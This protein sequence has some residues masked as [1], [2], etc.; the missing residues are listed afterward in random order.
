MGMEMRQEL[1]LSQQLVMTPQLQQAIKL[2]QLSRMELVDLVREEML[3][4][5]V[6]EE[7]S[8]MSPDAQSRELVGDAE[9]VTR[10]VE[11]AGHTELP[12]A[13]SNKD[14]ASEVKA[15]DS[16]VGEIDWES[17]L[18]D[19]SSGPSVSNFRPD[20]DDLPSHEATLT[21]SESLS[22]HLLWQLKMSAMDETHMAVGEVIIGNI[23]ASGYF[24]EPP[25]EDLASECE[26]SVDEAEEVLMK[27]QTFD[28]V[29]VGA[30]SLAECLLIQ[31]MHDGQDDE[32]VVK[33]IKSHL[34]NL[35]RK[36]YQAIARDLKQ[37]L[38]EVY[39]AAKVI[40]EF[41]PRPGR[42][43]SS[44]DPH[45]ITP[46]VY[47]HKVG[48]RYFVV[49]NDDGLPKLKISSFYRSALSKNGNAKDYIQDKLRSAQWL[50]RSIQQ[51]QRTIIKVSESILKFQRE[52]FDRGI[53][54]LRPLILRDVAEDIGM[55]ESTISRVTTSKY[56]HTPQGIFELKFFFNSGISRTDGDDLASQAVKSKIKKIIGD[57]DPKKPLSDQKIAAQ[58]KSGG[59]AIARR[60]VAKYR[61]QMGILSSSKRKQVF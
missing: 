22:E 26:V 59:I 39:E 54:H 23:D 42:Q 16:A 43:Y 33:I 18:D 57:E 31:A 12:V 21:R 48:D 45:Y 53:A 24:K 3:E 27:I 20:N 25:L 55:H 60:T 32:L 28:P 44:E 15:D 2:L 14:T 11:E 34:P 51:R 49:P 5:P 61:E 46:D 37:P 8:E 38:E 13:E 41:D 36:N 19:Y 6:L 58:L 10:Q 30:R 50:I 4:N 47:I 40:M 29:G 52:F 35:E 1:K 56:V 7:D 17:Y 9:Q